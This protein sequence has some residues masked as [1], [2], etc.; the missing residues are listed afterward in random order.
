MERAASKARFW[1]MFGVAAIWCC[2]ASMFI[3]M[4]LLLWEAYSVLTVRVSPEATEITL[5]ALG[6]DTAVL[7]IYFIFGLTLAVAAH[8]YFHGIL[9][10]SE[11]LKLDF[12]GLVFLVIPIGAF[13]EPRDEELKAAGESKRMR[14]FASGPATNVLIA[15][16]CMVILA[17]VLGPSIEPREEGALVTA[18]A[19]ESPARMFGLSTW[20]EVTQIQATPIR[21]STD[22]ISYWF[23]SPGDEVTVEAIHKGTERVLHVPSGVVI[24][25]VYEGPG[26]NAGLRPGMIIAELNGTTIHT[27]EMLRSVTENS[28]HKAPVDIRVLR[29]GFD[30]GRG[31]DWFVEDPSIR[32]INLTSKWLFYYKYYPKSANSDEYRNM[33]IM[34]V[35]TSP[36]GVRI[37]DM[38]YLPQ[39][40][41]H[42]LGG[43][44]EDKGPVVALLRFVALPT[45]GYS[46]V[47][48]PATELYQPSGIFSGVPSDVYWVVINICYWLFWAN[49][50]LGIANALP[51]LPFDGGYVL[52]DALKRVAHFRAVRISG[53]D[54]ALG[55]KPVADHDIDLAMWAISGLVY[56]LLVFLLTW[57]VIGPIF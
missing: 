21:T 9:V 53:L 54:R 3:L 26:F 41:T 32:Q 22:L 40:V 17:G 5:G 39:L 38:D 2:L 34:G 56:V 45:L 48:S 12:I 46:P 18:V 6:I 31:K 49:L 36:L 15:L 57:Q 4:L 8:E 35:S 27:V 44:T 47:V 43:G 24:T 42:P 11:K 37:E 51:A 30:P 14:V 23:D 10:F 13:V 52:R 25:A 33:S 20:S 7:A 1:R 55:K 16:V 50:I 28:T 19:D 29:Y